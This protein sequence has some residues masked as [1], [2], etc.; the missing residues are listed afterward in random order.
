MTRPDDRSSG[1]VIFAHPGAAA[2][3]TARCHSIARPLASTSPTGLSPAT[4]KSVYTFSTGSSV[5]AETVIA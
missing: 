2:T 5:G 4:I 3:V 1:L